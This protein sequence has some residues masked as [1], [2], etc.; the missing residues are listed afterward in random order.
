MDK[1][2]KMEGSSG[3]LYSCPVHLTYLLS[4]LSYLDICLI[5]PGFECGPGSLSHVSKQ[6]WKNETNIKLIPPCCVCCA[7]ER[8]PSGRSKKRSGRK[9]GSL[10][11]LSRQCQPQSKRSISPWQQPMTNC[12]G[13]YYSFS[14]NT[15]QLFSSYYLHM[16]VMFAWHCRIIR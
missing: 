1:R 12:C 2:G 16:Y 3:I 5:C 15:I 13:Y 9:G 4:L 14:L 6:T 8:R 7:G 11:R 10:T